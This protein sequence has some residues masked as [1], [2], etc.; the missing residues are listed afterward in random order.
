M[1]ADGGEGGGEGGGG[2]RGGG[3]TE[4]P[5]SV[6]WNSKV[7]VGLLSVPVNV[8]SATKWMGS[9]GSMTNHEDKR[10]KTLEKLTS[11]IIIVVVIP[12]S[13]NDRNE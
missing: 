9:L 3:E 13:G 4:K 1:K 6:S 11:I 5:A 2:G 8:S 10:Q 12:V 7:I